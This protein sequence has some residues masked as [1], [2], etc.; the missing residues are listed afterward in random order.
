MMY[1]PRWA[2]AH[3]PY[4]FPPTEWV[5]LRVNQAIR[6][7]SYDLAYFSEGNI[8]DMFAT[9]PENMDPGQ[10][11]EFERAFNA[12]LAGNDQVRRRI[13]FLPWKADLKEVRPFSFETTLDEWMLRVTCAAYGIPPMELGFTYEVNKATA[14]VQEAINQRRGLRPLGLW[15]TPRLNRIIQRYRRHRSSVASMPG[16]PTRQ[17]TN[18]FEQIT[19]QWH[20][21]DDKDELIQA[22]VD[23]I[24]YQ[25]GVVSPDEIRTMRYG[26]DLEGEAPGPPQQGMLVEPTVVPVAQGAP[27]VAQVAKF[28]QD[29]WEGYG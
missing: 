3:T 14:D 11:A 18:P 15:L 16:S 10:V 5:I 24:Y 23:Q 7:Q 8:P 19:W 17:V 12:L 1:E 6:K 29:G 27:G 25:I 2:R 9:P 20:Y 22:Q 26:D 4:G 21:G 28:F 13:H